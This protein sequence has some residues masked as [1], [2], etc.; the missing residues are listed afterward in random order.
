MSSLPR[1][2]VVAVLLFCLACAPPVAAKATTKHPTTTGSPTP[3]VT[4]PWTF[5]P[6]AAP[7]TAAQFVDKALYSY[8]CLEAN[9]SLCIGIS[10]GA[11]EPYYDPTSIFYIQLKSRERNELAGLDY[12]K[13]RW[14]VSFGTKTIYLS[15]FPDLCLSQPY[16][17]LNLDMR[18]LGL[19]PCTNLT[20]NGKQPNRGLWD[21]TFQNNINAEGTLQLYG[22]KLCVTVMKCENGNK[23]F[24]DP[25]SNA[26]SSTNGAV[27]GAYLKAM[28]CYNEPGGVAAN[29][30][31]QTFVQ[32]IDCA[33]GCPP[34]LQDNDVC[35][36]PCANYACNLDNGHCISAAPT[37]PTPAPSQAPVLS[38]TRFPSTTRAPTT[39]EPTLMPSSKK[40]TG[41]PTEG[42]TA[43][44]TG[45]PTL[46]PSAKP[47]TVPTAVPSQT[48]TKSPV[49]EPSA[50]P[51]QRPLPVLGT[52]L[53]IT[54]A[55]SS[56]GTIVA[57]V[58][59]LFLLFLLCCVVLLVARARR[60]RHAS[61]PS[62]WKS[63]VGAN[64]DAYDAWLNQQVPWYHRASCLLFY[65]RPPLNVNG[66]APSGEDSFSNRAR[67]ALGVKKPKLVGA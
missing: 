32:K 2:L 59:P 6:S 34:Y 16:S 37:P 23:D 39:L 33:V 49:R 67:A 48:P 36:L 13:N 44:P 50:S 41:Y 47:T 43:L 54:P 56:T 51:T 25:T 10:P 28:P 21:L 42:P 9:Q 45:R 66:W 4:H 17:G 26:A 55:P 63:P 29:A 64:K 60:R 14:D 61:D 57:V 12:K 52:S 18:M 38:P 15:R 46:R 62:N 65:T 11:G 27:N 40:P 22:T 31:V 8:M 3:S 35:D 7:T 53:P 20:N 24:C 5:F 58:V 30:G 19:F 1:A